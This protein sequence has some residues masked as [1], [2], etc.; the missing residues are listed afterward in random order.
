MA[1]RRNKSLTQRESEIMDALWAAGRATAEEVRAALP[2]P[3][4]D[5]TVRTLLRILEAK[6]F[7]RHQRRGR[8][9]LY[10]PLLPRDSARRSALR[11][12][13][14][15]FFGGSARELVLHLVDDDEITPKEL[16][17]LEQIVRLRKSQGEA[18]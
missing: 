18:K 1:T 8:A 7:V 2:Q 14:R 15:R 10:E 16:R 6:G 3:R 12:L 11:S 4:H 17:Q 9:F 13:V 5:S